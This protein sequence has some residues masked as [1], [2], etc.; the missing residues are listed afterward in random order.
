[1]HLVAPAELTR[2]RVQAKTDSLAEKIAEL[3]GLRGRSRT[4]LGRRRLS[5]DGGRGGLGDGYKGGCG[6]VRSAVLLFRVAVVAAVGLGG[7]I[8][9]LPRAAAAA[10]GAARLTGTGNDSGHPGPPFS[11]QSKC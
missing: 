3:V 4:L 11:P 8:Q 2:D 6:L 1:M 9:A 10:P 7:S 5:L